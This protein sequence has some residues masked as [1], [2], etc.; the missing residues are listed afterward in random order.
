MTAHSKRQ[1]DI[2][3]LLV[4][5]KHM[6]KPAMLVWTLLNTE[7]CSPSSR[8]SLSKATQT[9]VKH[10]QNI[11]SLS[12]KISSLS[13]VPPARVCK[14]PQSGQRS[15]AVLHQNRLPAL[16]L[17]CFSQVWWM[18]EDFGWCSA[19]SCWHT[20]HSSRTRRK[21][22]AKKVGLHIHQLNIKSVSSTGQYC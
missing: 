7:S 14:T 10:L 3:N 17:R 4:S 11:C 5:Y 21:E 13:S 8:L 18:L 16:D 9:S 19:F 15:E 20:S 2:C 6:E 22:M 12:D 1:K